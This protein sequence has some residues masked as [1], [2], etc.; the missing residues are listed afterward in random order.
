MALP[1]G[2]FSGAGL[3][4]RA[5]GLVMSSTAGRLTGLALKDRMY[6]IILGR[7]T[8]ESQAADSLASALSPMH[9][10][11]LMLERLLSSGPAF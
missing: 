9:S 5:L 7:H 4:M 1:A 3:P 6:R 11:R 8:S 2:E 10:L